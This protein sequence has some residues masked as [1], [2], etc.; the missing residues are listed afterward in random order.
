MIERLKNTVRHTLIYSISNIAAKAVGVLL[1]P[2]YT[3]KL[4][5]GQF[6]VWDLLDVTITIL[7]EIFILGQA[8]AII[9]VNNS[10]EFKERKDSSLFSI[11]VFILSISALLVIFIEAVTSLFPSYFENTYFPSPYLKLS[12]YIV[13]LRV[14]NNLFLSKVRA[15]E[16]SG[17]YTIISVLRILLITGLT[18]YFVGFAQSGILGILY[19]AAMGEAFTILLLLI[20][21]IP[22]MKMRFDRNILSE[23]LKFGLPLVFVTI[24]YYLLNL[25]DRYIIKYLLGA[26]AVGLYGFGYRVAGVLN[27]LLI[28]PFNLSFTPIAFKI[29]GQK[30]DGRYFSKMMTYSTFFFVWGFIFLSLFS[31]ELVNIFSARP[32]YDSVYLFIPVILLS[33]VFSGMRL[34]ATLGMLL[35]KNTKSIAWIT[36]GS[37]LLNI[38]LNFIFIPVYGLMAAAINTLI[39]YLLFYIITQRISDKYF[40]IPF[41]NRKLVIMIILGSVLSTAIYFLPDMNFVASFI[42]KVIVGGIFPLLLFL[43]GFYD[44]AE[45]DLLLNPKKLYRFIKSLLTQTPAQP[46]DPRELIQE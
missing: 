30:D 22:Q 12:A 31:K 5:L 19:S 15:D 37:A 46:V 1:I 39:A 41:E 21:V 10:E 18:V 38:I 36:I 28:L 11:T 8:S 27:M 33:Y 3:S 17:Y 40:K 2:L 24:G 16:Q 34:T 13:L 23:A 20:K 25:S 45:L 42:I 29:F 9:L 44:K 35:T 7:A 6:G 14:L 43:F 4:T 26:E 32:D